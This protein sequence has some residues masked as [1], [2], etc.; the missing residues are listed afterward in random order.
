M[1]EHV[2]VFGHHFRFAGSRVKSLDTRQRSAHLDC[3]SQ[4]TLSVRHP[5]N[6]LGNSPGSPARNHLFIAAVGI[7]GQKLKF[8]H[9]RIVGARVSDTLAIR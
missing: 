5:V 6:E 7:G 9:F 3:R 2:I 4:Q 8:A 1:Q